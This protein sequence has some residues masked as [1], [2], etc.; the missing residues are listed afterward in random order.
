M[1]LLVDSAIHNT[2]HNRA[3]FIEKDT[4]VIMCRLVVL[5]T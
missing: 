2:P 5:M 4:Q 1:K 3:R